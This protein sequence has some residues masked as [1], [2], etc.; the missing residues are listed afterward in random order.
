MRIVILAAGYGTR[1]YPLTFNLPKPL[2]PINGSP[3]IDFLIE[4]IRLLENHVSIKEIRVVCNNKFYPHFILWKKKSGTRATIVNDGSNTP[5]DRLGAIGDIGVA[6]GKTKDDWLIVGGD[7][8][9]EDPLVDFLRSAIRRGN[10]PVLGVHRLHNKKSAS[11]FGVV[12]LDREGRIREFLEKPKEPP[13]A[14]V[15]SCI[16]YFP[17]TSLSYLERFLGEGHNTDA[18]GKYIA[19]LARHTDVFGYVLTGRW[20][21]V[22][23]HDALRGAEKHF[24]LNKK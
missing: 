4:K 10:A 13:S 9:F 17:R 5:E 2:V 20:M 19:W 3:V 6:I 18:S 7:N 1:L 11:R 21:D 23:Q 16:Y 12:R 22:G 15:A 8:L 14:L 24:K